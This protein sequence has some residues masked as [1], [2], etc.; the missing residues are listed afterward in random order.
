MDRGLIKHLL[1][2]HYSVLRVCRGNYINHQAQN[3]NMYI[4]IVYFTEV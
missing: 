3:S 4:Y 1:A 2:P